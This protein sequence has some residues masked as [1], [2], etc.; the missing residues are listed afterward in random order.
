MGQDNGPLSCLNETGPEI[1]DLRRPGWVRRDHAAC[2]TEPGLPERFLGAV[3]LI[4]VRYDDEEHAL[5][6]AVGPLHAALS[7][8]ST[9]PGPVTRPGG[10]DALT[11]E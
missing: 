2:L 8:S 4:L 5:P 3:S 1:D 7:A 6:S 10:A 11:I 9:E